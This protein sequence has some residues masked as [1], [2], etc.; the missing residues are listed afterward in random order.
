MT[1]DLTLRCFNCRRFAY[2][3]LYKGEHGPCGYLC[4][5]CF[6]LIKARFK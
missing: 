1:D 4:R 2:H 6:D 3:D 5:G